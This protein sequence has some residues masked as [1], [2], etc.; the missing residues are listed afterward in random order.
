MNNQLTRKITTLGIFA[1]LALAVVHLINIPLL[2]SAPFLAYTPADAIILIATFMFGIP[3]GLIITFIVCIVQGF[4]INA[5]GELI[6]ILMNFLGTASYIAVAGILYKKNKTKKQA[7][8][9][10]VSGTLAMILTMII[11]NIL[12]TPIYTGMPRVAVIK[13][14]PTV[15]LPFNVIKGVLNSLITWLLYKKTGKLIGKFYHNI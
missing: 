6:G 1:A 11:L 14:I 3:E 2:P 8:L 10:L 4:G 5:N 15:F 12:F 13:M 7:L 9:A